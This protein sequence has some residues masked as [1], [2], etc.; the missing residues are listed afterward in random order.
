MKWYLRWIISR[1]ISW[2]TQDLGTHDPGPGTWRT[3]FWLSRQPPLPSTGTSS[4]KSR[5]QASLRSSRTGEMA[6]ILVD[7]RPT[8]PS[9]AR[10]TKEPGKGRPPLHFGGRGE[11]VSDSKQGIGALRFRRA[12]V[13][14]SLLTSL[15][16]VHN[17]NASGDDPPSQD[18]S[19]YLVYKNGL[20]L[21]VRANLLLTTE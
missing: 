19:A 16:F 10:S 8:F 17:T 7:D 14:F 6:A 11:W 1:L 4:P 9:S 15:P 12:S 13:T 20:H 3:D 18:G 5:T 2:R 21:R